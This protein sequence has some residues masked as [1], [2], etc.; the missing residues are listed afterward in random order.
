MAILADGRSCHI[1]LYTNTAA[2]NAWHL[3][4]IAWACQMYHICSPNHVLILLTIFSHTSSASLEL[5]YWPCHRRPPWMVSSLREACSFYWKQRTRSSESS[6]TIIAIPPTVTH[7]YHISV[8]QQ[9][10]EL[11]ENRLINK[12]L[13]NEWKSKD[14]FVNQYL[15]KSTVAISNTCHL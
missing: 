10:N 5:Y 15:L 14:H 13:C 1:I 7:R 3:P 2:T 4:R 11:T 9:A 8:W 12:C 6:H